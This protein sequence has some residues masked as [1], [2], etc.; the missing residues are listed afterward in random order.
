M[1]GAAQSAQW[2]FQWYK[3]RGRALAPLHHKLAAKPRHELNGRLS[4]CSLLPPLSSRAAAAAMG[5]PL[6]PPRSTTAA[7]AAWYCR[8]CCAA[9]PAAACAC[10]VRSSGASCSSAEGRSPFLWV[11]SAASAS[12]VSLGPVD[13]MRGLRRC[14]STS[15]RGITVSEAL[16]PLDTRTC[17]EG[18]RRGAVGGEI[19]RE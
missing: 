15:G 3:L 1:Q 17:R 9:A 14:L 7:A 4:G 13:V 2:R 6:T 19:G 18:E 8:C 12:G 5:L 16:R 10:D 11:T